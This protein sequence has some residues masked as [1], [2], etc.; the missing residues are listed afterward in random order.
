MEKMVSWVRKLGTKIIVKESDTKINFLMGG[1]H[2]LDAKRL[3]F[4]WWPVYPEDQSDLHFVRMNRF[5]EVPGG[6]TF[7]DQEG[8]VNRLII[9]EPYE[10]DDLGVF[11]QWREQ[12]ED[13]LSKGSFSSVLENLI[14][15]NE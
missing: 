14:K 8:R 13:Y 2:V 1:I 10:T 9:L 5:V 6:A 7:L 11:K 12:Q 15:E 4:I 3:E